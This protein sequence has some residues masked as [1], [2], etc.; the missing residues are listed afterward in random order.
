MPDIQFVFHGSLLDKF[1]IGG[2]FC[3]FSAVFFKSAQQKRADRGIFF[4]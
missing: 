2:Q 4:L 3:S 1:D